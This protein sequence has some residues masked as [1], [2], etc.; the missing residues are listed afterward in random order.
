MPAS[1]KDLERLYASH[2]HIVIDQT[3]KNL[4]TNFG[5]SEERSSEVARLMMNIQAHKIKSLTR[6]EFNMFSKEL[7]NVSLQDFKEA[8]SAEKT[9]ALIEKAA[10]A[11][12]ISNEH[13]KSVL[14][15]MF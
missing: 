11:N 8:N 7:L 13:M 3:S 9:E 10:A 6:S 15:E 14:Q 2:E 5:L 12:N 4:Q 1:S